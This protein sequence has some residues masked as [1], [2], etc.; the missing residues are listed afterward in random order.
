MIKNVQEQLKHKRR[1]EYYFCGLLIFYLLVVGQID[2]TF[3]SNRN[4]LGSTWWGFLGFVALILV[5]IY[6]SIREKI[7]CPNCKG[8]IEKITM[9]SAVKS[10]NNLRFCP[11]CSFDLIEN[12]K[13]LP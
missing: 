9:R 3:L 2:P 10:L 11:Y 1:K 7:L 6:Y 12:K 4:I 13:N 5:G 8:D